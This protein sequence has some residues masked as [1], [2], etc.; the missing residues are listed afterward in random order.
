M[1]EQRCTHKMPEKSHVHYVDFYSAH[2]QIIQLST[3]RGQK[4]NHPAT[5]TTPAGI[6]YEVQ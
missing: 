6:Y 1:R 3:A 2:V 5:T 4:K